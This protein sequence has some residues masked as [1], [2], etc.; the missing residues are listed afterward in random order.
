MKPLTI[1][2]TFILLLLV[3]TTSTA[4]AQQTGRWALCGAPLLPPVAGD[5]ANRNA[6]DTPVIGTADRSEFFNN[7]P[8][9]RLIGDAEVRRADQSITGEQLTYNRETS[10]VDAENAVSLLETD[11]LIAGE[12]ASYWLDDDRGRFE[13]VSEYRINVGHLQG[14]AATVIREDAM[15]TR[16]ERLTLSTCNPGEEI[17]HMRATSAQID[18]ETRQGQ[19]WN[20]VISVHNVPVFYTPYFRFPVGSERMTGFL[21]PT[22]SDSSENGL[23]L[24][25]PWYWNIAPNRDAT[26]TPIW[27]QE[28]GTL[29]DGEFRYREEALRGTITGAYLPSDSLYEEDRWAINQ[30]HR[31]SVGS[32][33]RGRLRHHQVSDVDFSNDFGDDINYRSSRFLRSD[34]QLSWADYGISTSIYAESYEQID[35]RISA[36]NQP[37]TRVPR[38]RL[39]YEPEQDTGL[40]EYSFESEFNQFDHPNPDRVQGQRLN[41][42]PK[43]GINQSSLA[44]RINPAVQLRHA[45]YN[46]DGIGSDEDSTPSLTVPVYTLDSRVFFERQARNFTGVY[47][48]LEPRIFYRGA[49]SRNQDDLPNFDTGGSSF[50]FSRLFRE[51][52][53]SGP[54]RVEDGQRVSI[55]A[56]TRYIDEGDGEEYLTYSIGQIFYLT[57]REEA[58]DGDS[59]RRRSD[60]AMELDLR[61]PQ[62]IVAEAAY[63]WDPEN[64]GNTN[65]T[66][67]LRWRNSAAQAVNVSLRRRERDGETTLSQGELSFGTSVTP[68]WRIFGGI[69]QDF[70]A[71]ETRRRFFGVQNEGCCYAIRLVQK[72]SI[73]RDS[74]S[75]NDAGL[76]R[77]IMLEIELKGLAGFGDRSLGFIRSEVD[78][79]NPNAFLQ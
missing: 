50:S 9:F 57:D 36:F 79:Y 76:G 5:P 11:L 65:L 61:L 41:V 67:S 2:H 58:P 49:P 12:R 3:T 70:D 20:T 56:T 69:L 39:G 73:I 44:Y 51:N 25:L 54:D 6:P 74:T 14:N 45:Q 10:R 37:Y 77:E 29:L 66:T 48:T 52:M 4:A 59:E 75:G 17:W 21:A 26:I 24:A 78:G 64:S 32:A 55:G 1:R 30:D 53:F 42:N 28:R 47:Q 63:Q 38:I 68:G 62:G 16:Y 13:N 60:I 71:G 19:A 35:T 8:I 27:Y 46:L 33:I 40:F 15:R 72:E 43:I 7:P 22:I 34:V 18:N 23:T 31:L